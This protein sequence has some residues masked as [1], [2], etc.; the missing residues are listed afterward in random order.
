MLKKVILGL[1]LL[2]T[3]VSNAYAMSYQEAMKQ[4][5]PIVLYIT[6]FGCGACRQFE[7]FFDAAKD[8]FASKF[9]FVKEDVNTS[10]IAAK[11]RVNSTPSVYILEP[12][13]RNATGIKYACI[14]QQSCFEN[15]LQSY[16]K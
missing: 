3:V 1:F 10:E 13:T 11:L 8:K 2:L 12:K 5:K 9:N 6:M 15:T 4:D 7:P 14:S 16:G